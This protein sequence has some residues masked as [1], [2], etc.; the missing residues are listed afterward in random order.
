MSKRRSFQD[1]LTDIDDGSLHEQLTELWPKVVQAVKDTNKP[2]EL[3]IKLTAKL[4]RGTM[5]VVASK[6]TTKL[7]APATNPTLFYT[8]EEGNTTRHDPKQQTLKMVTP[9]KPQA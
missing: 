9:I 8:D 4:D 6:V 5:L 2:G 3:T 1:V 7:P